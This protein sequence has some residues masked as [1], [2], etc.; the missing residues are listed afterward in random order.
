MPGSI[1]QKRLVCVSWSSKNGAG[2]T[3]QTTWDT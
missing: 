3:V 1:C 2:L